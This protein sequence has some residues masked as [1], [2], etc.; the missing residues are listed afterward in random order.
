MPVNHNHSLGQLCIK[1][2]ESHSS[3]KSWRDTA[4]P[5]GIFPAMARMIA[6]GHEPGHKI[7]EKLNLPALTLVEVCPNCGKAPI[8]KHHCCNGK[9]HKPRP[10]RLAIRLD[11]PHSAARSIRRHM[12]TDQIA[13]LVAALEE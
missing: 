7:R 6:N 1:L 13:A 11:D 2:L 4:E 5:Y 3:T 10:P 8:A 9:P 12:T